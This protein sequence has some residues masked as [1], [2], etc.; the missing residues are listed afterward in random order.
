MGGL[1]LLPRTTDEEKF[2]RHSHHDVHGGG[3]DS[4]YHRVVRNADA[5]AAWWLRNGRRQYIHYLNK[6]STFQVAVSLA[7]RAP[8]GVAFRRRITCAGCGY[9]SGNVMLA[10]CDVVMISLPIFLRCVLDI[11]SEAKKF[12]QV[13]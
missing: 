13:Y 4:I 3:K 2:F 1:G 11:W 7:G 6:P 12:A 10:C 5:L 8:G 9:G